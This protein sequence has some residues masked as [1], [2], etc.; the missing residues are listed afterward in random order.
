MHACR[1]III[2]VVMA[3]AATAVMADNFGPVRYD[4]KSDQLIVTVIYDG[5]NADHHFSIQW[6]RCHKLDLSGQPPHQIVVSIV[7]EQGNDQ[8][9]ERFTKIVKVSLAGLPCRPA[10]VTLLTAPLVAGLGRSSIDV[11]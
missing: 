3:A 2:A 4:S 1:L 7:D 11:P 8:A 9:K 6:G 10:R 5:T